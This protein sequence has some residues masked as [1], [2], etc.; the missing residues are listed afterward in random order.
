[1]SDIRATSRE[2][3]TAIRSRDAILQTSNVSWANLAEKDKQIEGYEKG[4]A[5]L[6]SYRDVYFPNWKSIATEE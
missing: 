1:M 5:R 6:K 2:L 3:A 4:L